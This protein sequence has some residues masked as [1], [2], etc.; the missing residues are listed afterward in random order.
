MTTSKNNENTSTAT[1]VE[2]LQTAVNN[3]LSTLDQERER[4]IITRRFGL[5]ERRETLEQMGE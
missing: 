4:E 1:M 2:Q 5:L 3:I